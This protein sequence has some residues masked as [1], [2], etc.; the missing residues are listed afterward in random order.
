MRR[1]ATARECRTLCPGLAARAFIVSSFGKTY[2]VTGWKVGTVAAPAALTAELRKVHQFN[3]FTVNTPVQHGLAA[4]MVQAPHHLGVADFYQRKRDLF[5]EGLSRTR[6]RLLQSEG[7]FFQCV[8]ISALSDLPEADFCRW[9]TPRSAW[10]RFRCRLSTAT[11]STSAWCAFA[12]PRRTRRCDWRWSGWRACEPKLE[13][14]LAPIVSRGH[15]RQ[16]L[17]FAHRALRC[18]RPRKIRAFNLIGA[19]P[20][21]SV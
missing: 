9:L 16:A 15:G 6:F 13:A 4:Y 21:P 11:R 20:C 8:D 18:A 17:G 1:C 3:V 10:Q 14:R 2:H 19:A 5:A 7:S 12:S